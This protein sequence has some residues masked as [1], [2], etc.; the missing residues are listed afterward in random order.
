[1][2]TVIVKM[3]T[4]I[5]K[6]GKLPVATVI[7]TVESIVLKMTGNPFFTTPTP[8][9][10]VVTGLKDDLKAAAAD[11]KNGTTAAKALVKVK[12]RILIQ[13]MNSLCAY[14]QTITDLNAVTAEQVALSAGMS[15]KSMTPRQK[16]I[17]TVLNTL[18]LGS[19]KV[20]CPRAKGDVAFE[21]EY[22]K[23]PADE[24]S[25]VSTGAKSSATRIVSGLPSITEYWFRWAAITKDGRGNWSDPISITVT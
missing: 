21:F 3:I 14:V 8:T 11:A 18:T 20:F 2:S 16:R 9:L 25:Y 5:L 12:R 1:M 10:T 4:V 7:S 19:V 15:V 22:T 6:L 13:S 17:F 24:R 23:T